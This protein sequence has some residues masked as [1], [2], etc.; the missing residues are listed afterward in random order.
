MVGK[1]QNLIHLNSINNYPNETNNL[2][3]ST[4]FHLKTFFI[5]YVL[6]STKIKNIFKK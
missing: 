3:T 4:S 6:Y 5:K 2:K 1:K